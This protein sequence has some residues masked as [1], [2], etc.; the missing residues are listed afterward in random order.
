[1]FISIEIAKIFNE[2]KL[3]YAV[4]FTTI[5][6]LVA[7]IVLF[8]TPTS[9]NNYKIIQRVNN[10]STPG[11]SLYA[12]DYWVVWP[13]VLRDMM[14]GYEAYGLG[15]RA[16]GNK[17]KVKNYVFEKIKDNGYVIVICLNE[18]VVNC[19]NQINSVVGPIYVRESTLVNDQVHKIKITDFSR[20]FVYERESFTNLPSNVGLVVNHSKQSDGRAGYLAYG[21]YVP[22]KAGKYKLT[23]FGSSKKLNGAYIDIVSDKGDVVYKKIELPQYVKGSLL[24]EVSIDIP[25]NALDLEVRV[26]VNE[27]D[28]L[29]FSGYKLESVSAFQ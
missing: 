8:V 9:F 15:Y 25:E 21:P 26:W 22:L 1:M 7:M 18:K 17:E 28:E 11:S 24:D 23:V 20:G 6:S 12:G 10:L 5:L 19:V 13:S 16:E 2:I 14:K 3:K 27:D 29:T 4:F